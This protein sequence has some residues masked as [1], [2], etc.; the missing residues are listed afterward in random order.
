MLATLIVTAF[1]TAFVLLA[2]LGHV[3]LFTAVVFKRDGI[4]DE[5][6]RDERE[7]AKTAPRLGATRSA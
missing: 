3:L 7:P 2:I 1:V 5:K 6:A 4:S